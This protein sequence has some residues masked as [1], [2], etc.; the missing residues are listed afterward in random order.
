MLNALCSW[1]ES[2]GG[3]AVCAAVSTVAGLHLIATPPQRSWVFYLSSLLISW[4]RE[5]ERTA[6]CR[7]CSHRLRCLR[8]QYLLCEH[9]SLTAKNG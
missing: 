4:S 1:T 9:P 6:T 2:R 8:Y 3:F 5:M 7:S